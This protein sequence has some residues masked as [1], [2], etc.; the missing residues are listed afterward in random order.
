MKINAMLLLGI[1]ITIYGL[2]I[3]IMGIYLMLL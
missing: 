3:I 2:M 1:V